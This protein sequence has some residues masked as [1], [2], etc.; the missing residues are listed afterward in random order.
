MVEEAAPDEF[1]LDVEWPALAVE[2]CAADSPLEA[3]AAAF[4][5]LGDIVRTGIFRRR[6][7]ASLLSRWFAM[8]ASRYGE[9]FFTHNP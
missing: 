2:L 4:C 9:L 6:Y 3:V 8:S 7:V 5:R 1:L